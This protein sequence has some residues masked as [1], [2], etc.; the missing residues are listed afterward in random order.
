MAKNQRSTDVKVG[1]FVALGIVAT[2]LS[3]FV[4]GQERKLWEKSAH[5]KARFTTVAGL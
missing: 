2:F 5:L 3:L 1:L 4:I